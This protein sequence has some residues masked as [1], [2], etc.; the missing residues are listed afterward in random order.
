M[1]NI[2][3]YRVNKRLTENKLTKLGFRCG[4]FKRF[5]YKQSI[6]I[7]I[8]IDLASF[9]WRYEI[10]CKNSSSSYSAYYN[11][12]YGRNEVVDKIDIAIESLLNEL[13]E[14]SF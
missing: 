3:D 12:E 9:S 6:E 7:E 5:V 14:K 1:V 8:K 4:S 10:A 2:K 11:R 13:V